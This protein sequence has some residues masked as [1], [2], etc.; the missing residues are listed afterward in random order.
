MVQCWYSVDVCPWDWYLTLQGSLPLS[1][2]RDSR[3]YYLSCW[4]CGFKE[5]I[6][7]KP[8]ALGSAVQISVAV[9]WDAEMS[10]YHGPVKW[11]CS[12]KSLG[13]IWVFRDQEAE[14]QVGG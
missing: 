7:G 6:H 2:Q 8:S 12:S 13:Q 1:V 5:L 9:S 3:N 11:S 4:F 10:L 14:G